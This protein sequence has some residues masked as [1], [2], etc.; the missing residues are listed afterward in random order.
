MK[1]ILR[2]FVAIFVFLLSVSMSFAVTDN[3][4]SSSGDEIIVGEDSQ[5]VIFDNS[6]IDGGIEEEILYSIPKIMTRSTPDTPMSKNLNLQWVQ[7]INGYY[8][9]PAA[10]EMIVKPFNPSI[11]QTTIASKNYFNTT[12]NGTDF[13]IHL[14]TALETLTGISWGIQSHVYS[15]VSTLQN[16][17]VAAITYGNGVLVNTVES[18]GDCYLQGHDAYGVLYHYGVIDAYTSYGNNVVYKD[19]GA[20][21]YPEFAKSQTVTITKMSYAI[22]GRGYLW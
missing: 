1:K 8:C 10:G 21:M 20:G 15:D 5:E 7:Q 18:P 4:I 2:L 14:K 11:T 9:A 3:E 6:A 13:G 16:R 19:P 17:V 12:T 22:G